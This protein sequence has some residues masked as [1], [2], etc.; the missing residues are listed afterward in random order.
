MQEL[1]QEIVEAIIAAIGNDDN[2]QG[3]MA[4]G[5]FNGDWKQ[6]D[7]ADAYAWLKLQAVKQDVAGRAQVENAEKN[8]GCCVVFT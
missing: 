1:T 3:Q 4:E 8:I 2:A 6:R 7:D 5:I